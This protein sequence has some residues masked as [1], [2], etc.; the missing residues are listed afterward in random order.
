MITLWIPQLPLAENS[1]LPNFT[2]KGVF[3]VI[4]PMKQNKAPRADE[5]PV[6]F[7]KSFSEIIKNDVMA[8]FA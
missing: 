6:E 4:F 2:C 7:Y 1:V 3:E 5:L 8:M